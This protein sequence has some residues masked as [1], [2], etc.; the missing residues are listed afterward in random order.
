MSEQQPHDRPAKRPR[1]RPTS[2]LG[3]GARGE[4]DADD[5]PVEEWTLAD[6][7]ARMPF[8]PWSMAALA[9]IDVAKGAAT[10]APVWL[11][12]TCLVALAAVKE[13]SAQQ[14]TA[15][16]PYAAVICILLIATWAGP[17]PRAQSERRERRRRWFRR[18]RRPDAATGC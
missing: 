12:G 14:I 15:W 6:E 2:P 7:I 8:G 4:P 16:P 17:S 10:T 11:G 9:W 1:D 3:R 5:G 18:H 13:L